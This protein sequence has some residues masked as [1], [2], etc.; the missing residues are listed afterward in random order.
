MSYQFIG[1]LLK[2]TVFIQNLS[3]KETKLFYNQ[4][5]LQG[6]DENDGI[7]ESTLIIKEEGGEIL[8]TDTTETGEELILSTPADNEMSSF[9]EVEKKLY[10]I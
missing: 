2:K 4:H 8:A 7:P 9:D 10:Y 6:L 5:V 1:Y 3:F